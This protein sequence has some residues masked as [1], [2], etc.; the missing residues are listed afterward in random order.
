M[1][2]PGG[3]AYTPV[4]GAPGDI[5]AFLSC[6]LLSPSDTMACFLKAPHRQSPRCQPSSPPD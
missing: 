5:D 6:G 1:T 2:R 3:P 4:A